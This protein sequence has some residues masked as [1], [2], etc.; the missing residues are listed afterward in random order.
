MRSVAARMLRPHNRL[1]FHLRV[2]SEVDGRPDTL[3]CREHSEIPSRA[4]TTTDPSEVTCKRCIAA[5]G[6]GPGWKS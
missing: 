3:W 4:T 6:C 2:T 5:G 1:V